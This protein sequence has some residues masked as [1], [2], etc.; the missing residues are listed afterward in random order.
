MLT[1]ALTFHNHHRPCRCIHEL[2]HHTEPHAIPILDSQSDQ[3]GPVVLPLARRR[4][5]CSWH[6][7]DGARQRGRRITI[8]HLLQ[9]GDQPVT[10]HMSFN[11]TPCNALARGEPQDP[12]GVF[13]Q[14]LRRFGV[15]INMC[16]ASDA[17]R[18]ANAA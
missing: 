11:Y 9:P 17:E 7:D 2:L 16:P 3:V 1:S 10:L 14:S 6:F 4:Q 8:L 5:L 15:G 13:E 18:G 12:L